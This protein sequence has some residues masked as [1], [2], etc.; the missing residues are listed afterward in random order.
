MG[1]SVY[2]NA[3]GVS[4]IATLFLMMNYVRPAQTLCEGAY[5]L[6]LCSVANGLMMMG[7]AS[8]MEALGS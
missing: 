3:W 4:S 2:V 5:L 7:T 6:G 1:R 8:C